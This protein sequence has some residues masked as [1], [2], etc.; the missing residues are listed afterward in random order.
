MRF[1]SDKYELISKENKRTIRRTIDFKN[2]NKVRIDTIWETPSPLTNAEFKINKGIFVEVAPNEIN[3]DIAILFKYDEDGNANQKLLN[4]KYT[5]NYRGIYWINDKIIVRNQNQILIFNQQLELLKAINTGILKD[6]FYSDNQ[7]II[8]EQ[9]QP[10]KGFLKFDSS[11]EL[12][13]LDSKLFNNLMIIKAV[14]NTL[15]K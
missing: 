4:F 15:Y 11:F 10:T 9:F 14:P 7:F 1:I 2:S 13:N 12:T 3:Q 8:F 5:G 6:I